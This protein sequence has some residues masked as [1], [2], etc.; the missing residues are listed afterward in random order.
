VI[1]L[2]QRVWDIERADVAAAEVLM[3]FGHEIPPRPSAWFRKQERQKPLRDAIAQA[4]FDHLRR[5]LFRGLFLPSLVRIED[6]AERKAEA[7][8]LW[9]AAEPLARMMLERLA[10]VRS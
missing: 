2:A 6:P 10:E 7:V 4:R 5:R 3:T 1:T 8:I 9:E